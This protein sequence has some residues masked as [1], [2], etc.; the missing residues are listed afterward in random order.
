M[1][2]FDYS[3]LTAEIKRQTE[4]MDQNIKVWAKSHPLEGGPKRWAQT[5][6]ITPPLL[7]QEA[8]GELRFDSSKPISFLY[9]LHAP[10]ELSIYD[11]LDIWI[12]NI[13][14]GVIVNEQ[15]VNYRHDFYNMLKQ[16]GYRDNVNG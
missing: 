7:N 3:D 6:Q 5:I 10:K 13:E 4:L 9:I 14:G 11:A 16:V 15:H 12:L 8:E 1:E 2:K